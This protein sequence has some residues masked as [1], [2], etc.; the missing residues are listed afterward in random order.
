MAA[1]VTERLD[2]KMHG[3]RIDKLCWIATAHK[4]AI[5]E[6]LNEH[7]DEHFKETF[8]KLTGLDREDLWDRFLCLDV[9]LDNDYTGFVARVYLPIPEVDFNEDGE[10]MSETSSISYSSVMLVYGVNEEQL[11][12]NI[13]V[14]CRD[15]YNRLIEKERAK[16]Q[17][18]QQ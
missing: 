9:L 13:H 16:H 6:L 11:L 4:N 8:P 18:S 12:S 2:N 14:R 7:C 5:Y 1:N 15:E 10:V 3:A 17:K